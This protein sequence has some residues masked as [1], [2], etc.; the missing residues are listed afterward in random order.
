MR[1]MLRELLEQHGEIE[2]HRAGRPTPRPGIRV[3]AG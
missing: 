1:R 3:V 2:T